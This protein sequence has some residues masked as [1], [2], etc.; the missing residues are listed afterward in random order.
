MPA[1]FSFDRI[2]LSTTP[3]DDSWD[4]R[5]RDDDI[6]RVIVLLL[7][8]QCL[9]RNQTVNPLPK[10]VT[11]LHD[12]FLRFRHISLVASNSHFICS[13]VIF[14]LYLSLRIVITLSVP[15]ELNLTNI[16]NEVKL[17]WK[18]HDDVV[19]VLKS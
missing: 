2:D 1:Y 17:L 3:S 15:W 6:D 16:K 5:R 13:E 10:G 7:E 9:S 4:S 18:T 8:F 14:L 12:L 19:L 11:H